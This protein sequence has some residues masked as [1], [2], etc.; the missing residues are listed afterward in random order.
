MDKTALEALVG[1]VADEFTARLNRGEQPK[2]EEYV[3]LY[4]EAAALL[5]G[6][7][8]TLEVL[9]PDEA[10]PALEGDAVS[11]LDLLKGCLGDFRIIR[12]IGRGGMGIVYEAEQISLGRQVALK[13]LPFA[14]ALDE[15]RLQRFKHEAQAA[16][17][18]HHTNIV[19]VFAIGCE[20][21]VHFYAMQYIAG[22]SLAGVIREL[23]PGARRES[24]KEIGPSAALSQVSS[25]MV[26]GWWAGAG[27]QPDSSPSAP[28]EPA[29]ETRAAWQDTLTTEHSA[30]SPLF[31]RTVARLGIQAAEA[32]EYAH[33][34]GVVHRDIKP[35]NLLV[36]L[37]GDL[38]VTD[39]GMAQFCRDADL[40]Q[41]GELLGTLRYMSPEQASAKPG[42]VD[43]HTDVYSLGVTLYELATLEPAFKGQDREELLRQITSEEPAPPRRLKA[44]LPRELETIILKAIAKTPEERYGSS[45]ELAN[46][47]RR[48]LE[49]K[50]ILAKRPSL[51]ERAAKWTRRHKSVV[52]ALVG[53]L[54]IAAVGLAFS[55]VMVWQ[56]K[57]RIEKARNRGRQ[58]VNAMY[59]EFAEKWLA[60]EPQLEEV[61]REFLL[62]ALRFY[63]EE[64]EE[65]A[66]DARERY[67]RALAYQRVADIQHRFGNDVAATSAY[68]K[69]IALLQELVEA[70]PGE[71]D[72]RLNLTRCYAAW[73]YLAFLSGRNNDA[74]QTQRR[75]ILV[76]EQLV[77]EFPT[78]PLVRLALPNFRVG[79]GDMLRWLGRP[80]EAE[81]CFRQALPDLEQ[82][83]REFPDDPRF[84]NR[85]GHI[86]V[87]WGELLQ[88]VGSSRAED[89]YRKALV[90]RENL[91]SR[92]PDNP[93][94]RSGWASVSDRLGAIL[95]ADGKADEAAPFL[96]QS[97]AALEEMAAKYPKSVGYRVELAA[98]WDSVGRLRQATGRTR[99]AE[100][101][102][103]RCIEVY[104]R[105]CIESPGQVG[106][107]EAPLAQLYA[108]CPVER[109]RDPRRAVEL[110]KKA[111]AI[112]P[113]ASSYWVTLG[114]AHYRRGEW[115]A[116][117]DA[118]ETGLRQDR[119]DT[120]RGSFFLAM[121]YARLG[122]AEQARR[123]FE[124]AVQWMDTN[125]PR[126]PD[127]V[128][129]RAEAEGLLSGR[130]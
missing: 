95:L 66:T 126:N 13:V 65:H 84:P 61:Q 86:L 64:A 20:R 105:L 114:V 72:S 75:A 14:A 88:Q 117:V 28:A 129:V 27:D 3:L 10:D 128:R 16:A 82:L 24:A 81:S 69:A 39:F 118:L 7:L 85:L 9:H 127:L 104:E 6:I 115:K 29:A 103:R 94:Y 91:S 99:D 92:H 47:L 59:T 83:A 52:R 35:A 31:F 12:E 54:V 110:G 49:D 57:S 96:Y 56:A 100:Q 112:F 18:L 125:Q 45:K 63:E 34:R 106:G 17:H 22:Q 74:E 26:S 116:A 11:A 109:L 98:A 111:L 73:A 41:S 76:A 60:T 62:K 15:K 121:A 87:R 30:S 33:N 25:G 119:P 80:E 102:F 107:Y 123:S 68:E 108:D 53:G 5:R 97:V 79:L 50:P 130:R 44:S 90:I 67:E 40:T 21:G 120:G 4:P 58:A 113:K 101:A 36:D 23:R 19:P 1:H 8:P 51:L 43:H 55:T 32:L 38:W 93:T 124:Q 42:L 89:L 48:F 77:S 78:E 71:P 46:D 37:R 2:V 70:F 122:N